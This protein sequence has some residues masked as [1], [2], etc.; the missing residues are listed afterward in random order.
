MLA[1]TPSSSRG[2]LFYQLFLQELTYLTKA[3]LVGVINTGVGYG[4]I[5]LCTLL[6]MSPYLSNAAGYAAGLLCSFFLHKRYVFQGGDKCSRQF[7]YFILAFIIAYAVNFL[8]LHLALEKGVYVLLAQAM[9]NL[10]YFACMYTFGRALI[11]R[12]SK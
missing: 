12:S 10:S 8:T 6:G 2:R 9:G 11:F 5:F 1:N 7:G 4:V 3:F